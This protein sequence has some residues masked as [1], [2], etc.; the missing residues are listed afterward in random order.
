M[1]H[2]ASE[3]ESISLLYYVNMICLP[4]FKKYGIDEQNILHVIHLACRNYFE[5]SAYESDGNGLGAYN[6]VKEI[7]STP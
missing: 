3:E 6:L 2:T 1:D 7:Y 5:S 4:S